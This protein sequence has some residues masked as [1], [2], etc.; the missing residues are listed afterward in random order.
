MINKQ[1]DDY[2]N[3]NFALYSKQGTGVPVL[4]VRTTGGANV[5][6]EG[7]T[8]LTTTGWH[9]IAGVNSGTGT[10]TYLY[11]NGTEEASGLMN[12]N[13]PITQAAPLMIGRENSTTG[14]YWDG[15]I[16]EIRISKT[17]RNESWI[18]TTYNT[19]SKPSTFLTIGSQETRNVAP[20]QTNPS[21]TNGAKGASLNP[22]L[23]I[24]ISDAN[25]D[26]MNV[27]F[28]TN[29]TGAWANIGTNNTVNNGTYR[30]TT[31]DMDSYNTKY[32][33]SVNLTDGKLWTNNTYSFTTYSL[34][35]IRPNAV[36]R[37]TQLT[38]FG[39][40][41]NY[42]C[43]DEASQ[44]GDTDYVYSDNQATYINDTYNLTDHTTETG[45]INFIRIYLCGKENGS[46]GG[47]TDNSMKPIIYT[48]SNYYDS[49][50]EATL[51]DS[52]VI[53]S[54][55]NN[56]NPITSVAWTWSEIDNLE[57]GVALVGQQRQYSNCTQVYIEVVYTP[58]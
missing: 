47:G 23:A 20:T 26:T 54:W 19:I 53:S 36:G 34:L 24:T 40:A 2:T 3:R 10:D 22:Q 16:D 38:A 46:V 21:P 30:Q 55:T 12:A 50:T 58:S 11:V 56:V 18:N 49:D 32:W 28:R 8:D 7:T 13:P 57:V 29:A 9:Y 25:S 42:Q 45:N 1:L 17:A 48:N 35:T 44:N 14:N 15:K 39:A 5:T 6:R 43:V 27:I 41:Q 33:W 37:S 51:T 52:Y 4:T 31:A